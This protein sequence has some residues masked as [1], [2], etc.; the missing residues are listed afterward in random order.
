MFKLATKRLEI[1]LKSYGRL[2]IIMD[3]TETQSADFLTRSQ[4]IQVIAQFA[5][6]EGITDTNAF[7][8][9]YCGDRFINPMISLGQNTA[10]KTTDF[11]DTDIIRIGGFIGYLS[12][13]RIFSPA[14][15]VHTSCNSLL[16]ILK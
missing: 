11:K 9:L 6:N 5:V 15:F 3:T 8:G 4:W 2:I 16:L 10:L 12:D 14:S 13:L 1:A 7:L